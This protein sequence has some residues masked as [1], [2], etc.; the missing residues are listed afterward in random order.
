[1]ENKMPDLDE[2]FAEAA[3]EEA[4]ETVEVSDTSGEAEQVDTPDAESTDVNEGES[5][6]ADNPEDGAGEVAFNWEDYA[7]QLIPV[8]R[9]GEERMVSLKQLRDEGMMHA[10]YTQKT[11]QIAER[12]KLAKWAEDVQASWDRHPAE[13]MEAFAKAYGLGEPSEQSGT[14]LEDLDEDVRPFAEQTMQM[15][16]ELQDAQRQLQEFQNRRIVDDVRAEMRDLH[17]RFGD[18]FDPEASLRLAAQKNVRLEDAHLLI[19]AQRQIQDQQ[20]S[21]QADAAAA[22]AAAEAAKAAESKRAKQKAAATSTTTSSFQAS[23]ISADDFNDIGELME[24][25]MASQGS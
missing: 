17:S 15:R 2:L 16:Q 5:E 19:M 8:N 6:E 25:I 1:M 12:E 9:G 21:S 20:N 24:Q 10:D 13:T 7:D 4:G 18:Q 23:D 11:Q 14:R 22:S 3:A